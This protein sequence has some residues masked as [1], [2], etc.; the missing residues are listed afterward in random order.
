MSLDFDAIAF[1]CDG[2]LSAIEGITELARYNACE[3]KIR[4]LTEAAMSGAGLNHKLFKTRLDLVRP[5]LQQTQDVAKAYYKN[6]TKN[7][8]QLIAQL[9]NNNKNVYILSAGYYTAVVDFAEK[10]KIP[11]ENVFAVKLKFNSQGEYL[12]FDNSSPLINNSGKADIIKNISQN[13]KLIYVGDGAND[14]AVKPHVEKFIGFGA[15]F[16]RENIKRQSDHYISDNNAM[17]IWD[18]INS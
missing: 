7:I 6:R 3:E 1:D 12:D 8:E 10:L 13:Q 2:T 15:H 11:P 17:L 9:Q 16:Y 4:L 18:Y 5:T 14:L